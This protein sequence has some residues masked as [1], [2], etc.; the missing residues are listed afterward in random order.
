MNKYILKNDKVI[1][2]EEMAPHV[3]CYFTDVIDDEQVLFCESIDGI[4][5]PLGPI[6]GVING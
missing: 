2:T 1:D 6:K 5:Y 4:I 3:E